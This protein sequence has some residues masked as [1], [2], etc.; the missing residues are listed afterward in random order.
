[1]SRNATASGSSLRQ[2]AHRHIL[3][4]ARSVPNKAEHTHR[5]DVEE[6]SYGLR[7]AQDEGLA[8]RASDPQEIRRSAVSKAREYYVTPDVVHLE[9]L[10]EEKRV[11]H[12]GERGRRGREED[13]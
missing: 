6:A 13:A 1:M 4:R 10:G 5:H 9:G 3:P 7:A 8:S 11:G 12:A 2:R